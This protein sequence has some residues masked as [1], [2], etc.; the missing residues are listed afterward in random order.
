M[1]SFYSSWNHFVTQ[2]FIHNKIKLI[3]IH[4][5]EINEFDIEKKFSEFFYGTNNLHVAFL[6]FYYFSIKFHTVILQ[7]ISLRL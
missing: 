6:F 5:Y 2:K 7:V 4:W 1:S 3:D